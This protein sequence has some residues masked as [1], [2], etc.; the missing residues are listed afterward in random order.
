MLFQVQVNFST[1]KLQPGLET[2]L[3]IRFPGNS[4]CSLSVYDKS[5]ETPSPVEYLNYEK[6]WWSYYLRCFCTFILIY[7][8][9]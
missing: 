2:L 1:Q 9:V 7:R 3:K 5:I 4:L 8:S 6:V